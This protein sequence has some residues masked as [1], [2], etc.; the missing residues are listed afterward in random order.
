[1]ENNF[2]RKRLAKNGIASITTLR[3]DFIARLLVSQ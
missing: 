1:M 3:R 2:Q